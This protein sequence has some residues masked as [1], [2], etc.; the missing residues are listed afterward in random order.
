MTE[1]EAM[2]SIHQGKLIECGKAE[3]PSLRPAIQKYAAKCIDSG[4]AVRAM[5]ALQEVKRLDAV[6]KVTA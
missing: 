1:Q 2:Q 6:H 3:W 5:I 4:D